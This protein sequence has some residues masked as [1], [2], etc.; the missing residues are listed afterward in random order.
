[1]G[2]LLSGPFTSYNGTAR[3]YIA[4]INEDGSLDAT[5]NP[6]TGAN[7]YV[8]TTAIQSDGKIIIGGTFTSYKGMGRN[9]IARLDADGSLDAT[10]NPGTGAN[11]PVFTTAIQSDGKIIIGGGFHSYNGTARNY[12]ARI[13]G[14]EGVG[15]NEGYLDKHFFSAYPNP[16][17]GIFQLTFDPMPSSNGELEIYNVSG[18]K[19][20][21]AGNFKQQ[22]LIDLSALAKGIYF[23]KVYYETKVYHQ[24][25]VVQ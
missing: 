13:N 6:G 16:S 12:I 14:G 15:V 18:E 9:C 3:N 22:M 2:K 24:K 20:F 21:T 17:N 10:F 4:R 11:T 1:M 7:N 5:F 8:L 25:I 19:V 23:V